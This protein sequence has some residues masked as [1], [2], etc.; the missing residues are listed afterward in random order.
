[1]KHLLQIFFLILFL[2]ELSLDSSTPFVRCGASPALT[3]I[4]KAMSNTASQSDSAGER[5]PPLSLNQT[6]E[7]LAHSALPE[8]PSPQLPSLE[9]SEEKIFHFSPFIYLDPCLSRIERPP[10][11]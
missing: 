11:A 10:I 5:T 7:Y 6:V 4:S 1:V 3:G 9:L 8:F 2:G